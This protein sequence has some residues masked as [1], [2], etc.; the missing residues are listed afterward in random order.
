MVWGQIP[1]ENYTKGAANRH[2]SAP[3]LETWGFLFPVPHIHLGSLNISWPSL[4]E[5]KT[6]KTV[7]EGMSEDGGS[8]CYARA[9]LCISRVCFNPFHPLS[10]I[11]EGRDHCMSLGLIQELAGVTWA[12]TFAPKLRKLGR[13][14]PFQQD[15]SASGLGWL[16]G[17]RQSGVLGGHQGSSSP[18]GGSDK[19]FPGLPGPGD[20]PSERMASLR[21]QARGRAH[22]QDGSGASTSGPAGMI[23]A[24]KEIASASSGPIPPGSVIHFRSEKFNN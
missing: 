17:P 24:A 12:W 2:I 8:P 22:A 6:L 20:S 11:R 15:L 9:H 16:F 4:S 10:G 19:Q 21:C 18:Q 7:A 1:R 13:A 3:V 14:G 23:T 5:G